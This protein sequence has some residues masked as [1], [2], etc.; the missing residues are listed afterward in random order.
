MNTKMLKRCWEVL[1]NDGY[2]PGK[3]RDDRNG[4][5]KHGAADHRTDLANAFDGKIF[6]ECVSKRKRV[7]ALAAPTS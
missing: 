7:V 5:G 1:C 2:P 6:R 3:G 4:G